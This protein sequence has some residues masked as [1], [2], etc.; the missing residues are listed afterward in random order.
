MKARLTKRNYTSEVLLSDNLELTHTVKEV[1]NTCIS[2]NSV[3][4][5]KR[6]EDVLAVSTHK[7]M[8]VKKTNTVLLLQNSGSP[9]G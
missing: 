9:K 6:H 4:S 8:L 7:P 1:A 2:M 5:P 3:G